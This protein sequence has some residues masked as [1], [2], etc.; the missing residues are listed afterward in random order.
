MKK[1]LFKLN[2]G[3]WK[4]LFEG[5]FQG[6]PVEL[7][8]NPDNFLLMVIL[9]LGKRKVNGAVVQLH[10]PFLG[11]GSLEALVETVPKELM[12]FEKRD[13]GMTVK[14]LLISS[15]A[16]YLKWKE[17]SFQKEFSKKLKEMKN[18]AKTMKGHA[19][20][21]SV[22]LKPLNECTRSVQAAFFN[23]PV[24]IPA[25]AGKMPREEKRKELSGTVVEEDILL[26]K[27]KADKVISEQMPDF[28]E[29][30]VE[31]GKEKDRKHVLHV[32]AE[33]ALLSHLALTVLDW[34]DDFQGLA[35][36]TKKLK[37]LKEAGIDVEP[38][39]FPVKHFYPFKELKVDV[40]LLG[41]TAL[42]T[43]FGVGNERVVN[44]I[45]EKMRVKK[46][47]G[48]QEL[49]E[50]IKKEK[51]SE[52]V[53]QYEINK[54]VRVLQLIDNRYPNLFGANNP[55]GEVS[56]LWMKGMGRAGIVHLDQMPDRRSRLMLIHSL[57]KGVKEFYEDKGASRQ[58]KAL[59]VLPQA[60][61]LVGLEK[62]SVLQQEMVKTLKE[63]NEFG[64]GF[65]LE[66]N[67]AVDLDEEITDQ[68]K[69]VV[70]LVR[71]LDAA[72]NI[73]GKK[74]LRLEIRPTLSTNINELS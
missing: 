17:T 56:S 42:T 68:A 64:V 11:K 61:K 50:E 14:W 53:N 52:K 28:S 15:Q 71:G 40:N 2:D 27:D 34:E 62:Q 69:T 60:R 51:A 46:Y 55:V 22:G 54:A 18:Y 30:I 16:E 6:M 43:L 5:D 24:L 73:E 48:F 23:E 9:D 59:V 4:K 20:G 21:Y 31:D 57:L 29:T 33:S 74:R 26:G 47:S 38:I 35:T 8:K 65:V 10:Y 49:I 70:S 37:G 44:L 25:L 3:P 67:H 19:K 66:S 39:G 7:Y 36:S 63:F 72:I 12:L 58:L 1:E 41:G 13:K 32:L 45:R